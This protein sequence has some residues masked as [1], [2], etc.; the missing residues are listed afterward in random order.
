VVAEHGGS[1]FA[2]STS[3]IVQSRDNGRSWSAALM[4]YHLPKTFPITGAENGPPDRREK[5]LAVYQMEFSA[6]NPDS[7]F[8]VTNGGLFITHDAGKNWCL[9]TFGS[10][11]F[12]MVSSV[13]LA[14]TS[15]SHVF[16]TTVDRSGPLLWESKNGGQSFQRITLG[17]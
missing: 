9:T 8:F 1:V 16:V 3:G 4:A 5:P 14:N 10:D 15:G 13:A 12:N 11:M 7:A 6:D 2:V 17:R